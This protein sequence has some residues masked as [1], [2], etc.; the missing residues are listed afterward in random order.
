M[1]CAAN[2]YDENVRRRSSCHLR[3]VLSI[4]DFAETEIQNAGLMVPGDLV[5][6]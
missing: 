3:L 5:V 6:P 1:I 4:D 2:G